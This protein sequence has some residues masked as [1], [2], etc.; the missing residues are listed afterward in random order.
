VVELAG[1]AAL[2]SHTW[3]VVRGAEVLARMSE[4]IVERKACVGSGIGGA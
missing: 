2:R 4:P 1:Y 3:L